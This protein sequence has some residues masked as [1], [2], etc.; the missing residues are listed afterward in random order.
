MQMLSYAHA[1]SHSIVGTIADHRLGRVDGP[2]RGLMAHVNRALVRIY[3][4]VQLLWL[5]IAAVVGTAII[6][7]S[8][9]MLPDRTEGLLAWV[10]FVLLS[11]VRLRMQPMI[12]YLFAV[13]E[14]AYARR[15][16]S[17][18]WLGGAVVTGLSLLLW[19][20]IVFVMLCLSEPVFVQSRIM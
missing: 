19:C 5:G 18:D 12:A 6:W 11:M 4:W 13:G 14:T 1:G 8:L 15:L 17:F 9:R 2:S 20:N 3:G 7:S 10:A 16:E